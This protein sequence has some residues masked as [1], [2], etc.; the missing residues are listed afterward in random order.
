MVIDIS[1]MF[2][3]QYRIGRHQSIHLITRTTDHL[4][5][6]TRS[7]S[8]SQYDHVLDTY[9]SA[10]PKGQHN[11]DHTICTNRETHRVWSETFVDEEDTRDMTSS[12]E[13]ST[14][15]QAGFTL[16]GLMHLGFTL[17]G[18]SRSS[19]QSLRKSGLN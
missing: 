7:V 6:S 8:D 16:R 14:W 18:F 1:T 19:D 9:R 13:S 3:R 11:Y 12:S 4:K 17:R 10:Q 2:V 15:L 5:R